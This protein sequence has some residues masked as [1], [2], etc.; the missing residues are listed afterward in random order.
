MSVAVWEV[1]ADGAFPIWEE[2]AICGGDA[3]RHLLAATAFPIARA[4][5]KPALG[6]HRLGQNGEYEVNM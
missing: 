1:Y 3:L 6:S 2:S 5:G 4:S